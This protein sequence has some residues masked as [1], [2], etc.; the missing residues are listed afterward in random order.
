[1]CYK[2]YKLNLTNGKIEKSIKEF[3][4][5]RDSI[6]YCHMMNSVEPDF[7]SNWYYFYFEIGN[8]D[9]DE[10]VKE[11]DILNEAK[12]QISGRMQLVKN[13]K[14]ILDRAEEALS[15]MEK[16]EAV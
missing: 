14:N 4:E 8:R 2:I 1:M 5:K 6:I 11:A 3:S 16:K 13:E 15:N 9:F 10:F 12:R 7:E